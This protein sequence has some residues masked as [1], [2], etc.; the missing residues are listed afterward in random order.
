V[1]RR[2]LGSQYSSCYGLFVCVNHF[3]VIIPTVNR[4]FLGSQYSFC[5]VLPVHVHCLFVKI[6]TLNHNWNNEPIQKNKTKD[7]FVPPDS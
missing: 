2:F 1:D 7:E 5:D 4:K 3:L 6:S